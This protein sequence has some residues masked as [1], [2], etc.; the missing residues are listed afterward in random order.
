MTKIRVLICGD[1]NWSHLLDIE[2]FIKSLPSDTVIIEGECRGADLMAKSFA[3][4]Y[5][6]QVEK[7]PANWKKY[8]KG[9]GIIRNKEM[10]DKGNPDFVV[11][12]HN[13]LAESKGTRNMVKQ[14]KDKGIPVQIYSH[15]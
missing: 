4:K 7:F 13:N 6:L 3:L 10:L 9:A 11:A 15:E 12:F 2:N 14:A 8:G 5:H 1:R